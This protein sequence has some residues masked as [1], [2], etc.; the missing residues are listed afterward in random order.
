MND[1]VLNDPTPPR[2][3]NPELTPQ[4]EEIL[5]RALERDPR[6]RYPTAHEM[7]WDLTHQ[8][9]IGI[10]EDRATRAPL[11][12]RSPMARRMLFYAAIVAIPIILFGLMFL[13]AKR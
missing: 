13:F 9:Q 7:T 8:D 1:R 6:H 5:Y 2:Q 3:L 4:L 12:R 11:R 10:D